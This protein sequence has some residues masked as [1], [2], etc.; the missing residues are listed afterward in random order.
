MKDVERRHNLLRD[1]DTAKRAAAESDRLV[2][3]YF[4]RSYAP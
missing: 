2:F 4:T 1:L 3:G